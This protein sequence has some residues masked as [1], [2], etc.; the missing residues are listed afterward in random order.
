M[1]NVAFAGARLVLLGGALAL[2]GC[3]GEDGQ[4]GTSCTVVDNG[5]GTKTISCQDGTSV[6]VS[7][8]A[9]GAAG[10][11][12]TVRDNRNGTKTITCQDGT[13]VIIADGLPGSSGTEV[14]VGSVHGEEFLLST[15]EYAEAGKRLVSATI[16][17]ASADAAGVVTVDFKVM[18]GSQPVLGLTAVQA[19]IA[20]L[21]PAADGTPSRWVDYIQRVQTV[22]GSAT[23][24][25]PNPDGTQARQATREGNGT[26][27]E[28]GDGAYR[29]VFKTNLSSA[30]VDGVAIPYE[31]NLT[32]R[33]QIMMGGHSGPT[34]EAT[35]D[36]VPAGGAVTVTRDIVQTA[37]CV[38]C[39]GVEFHGHGGD[40]LTMPG[41]VTCHSSD[42]SP[43]DGVDPHGG[44][45]ID[46]TV[47][48]HK[49]HAGGALRTAPGPDGIIWDDPAT[50]E[51][52]SED[53]VEYAIWGNSNSKH[54]WGK[55]E[56]P[57]VIANC[58]TCHRGSGAQ[59]GNWKTQPSRKACGS[60][61]DDVDFATG[62]GHFMQPDDSVCAM[63]HAAEGP[64]IGVGPSVTAAHDFSKKDIRKIPEFD[65]DLTISTPPN[66][67]FF[68]TGDVPV[69][70][71]V[72]KK[73]G[74]PIDHT[75]VVE[76]QTA[77]GC[78]PAA[79]REGEACAQTAD[80][81]FRN[82]NM[83]VT[84]PRARRVPVLSAAARAKVV[85][86]S[87]GPWDLSAGEGTLRV[88]VDSGSFVVGY[89][90]AG[91]DRLMSGDFTVRLPRA[92]ELGAIFANPAAATVD[93]VIAWLMSDRA[94]FTYNERDFLFRDRAI[95][96]KD[97]ATGKLAIRSRPTIDNTNLQVPEVAAAPAS[98][99]QLLFT[100]HGVKV[101]GGAVQLRARQSASQNDAKAVRTVDKIT[102][103]LDPIDGYLAPGTYVVNVEFADLGRVNMTDNY[104]T[105]SVAVATFQVKQEAEEKPIAANCNT[106]HWSS[107]SN[108]GY[109]LDYPRHNK[110]FDAQA[111]D[112]CGGCHDYA[113]AESTLAMTWTTG[114]STKPISRRVH[115][116]H[117]GAA[118]NYPVITV[119]HEESVPGRNWNIVY[120]MDVRNCE[121]CHPAGTT[122][123]TWKTNPNRIACMGCHDA[124][125]AVAHM[126]LM[127][128]DPTPA[129]AWSGDEEEACKACH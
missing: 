19:L 102:Y 3:T 50:A 91:E 21:V 45:S 31:R 108:T 33:A 80:G 73:G 36:F 57:A 26:Q 25:W 24:N 115:S 64:G 28:L 16:L 125:A 84:G 32:H 123:G 98:L 29:Y 77:E 127:T 118:L 90:P 109:V 27:T 92:A 119:D 110:V 54:A 56:F 93:E 66:G 76:D 78:T 100:D 44:Q 111:M 52:E 116:I 68:V 17:S 14:A 121:S 59:A 105:P 107:E 124:D 5:N 86:A 74:V 82:A 49:I 4:D 83:Y 51:D 55:A 42:G 101:T 15:G 122:S 40:R 129:A 106:C 23:G 70:T 10:S 2:A 117:N 48:T 128:Y 99:N 79:G 62:I 67:K 22:S 58:T 53:N 97:E 9:E 20:K 85:S 113:S 120:P 103:T 61:H 112:Q 104:R 47:M 11:S 13:S 114:G 30:V 43:G 72:L 88:I 60:C 87:A 126:K 89:D 38:G 12:C 65:I 96:F 1:R 6:T 37:T 75:T 69:V 94:A 7:D 35:F 81:E 41:C 95:A 46:M 71:V 34:A 8:G 18:D 39:H 63:C